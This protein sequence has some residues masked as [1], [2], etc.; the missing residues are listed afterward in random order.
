MAT[1]DIR[2]VQ[3]DELK[4][5]EK[6]AHQIWHAHYPGI[7]SVAQI[8]Y[9]LALGYAP[10]VLEQNLAEGTRIDVLMLD[11]TMTGF[12][13]YGPCIRRIVKLHKCYLDVGAH[14]QGLGQ[15]MLNHVVTEAAHMKAQTLTLQ[16]NKQNQ[17]AIRAYVRRGFEIAE[18]VVD[19]IG[20]GFV[21]DDYVMSLKVQ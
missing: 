7:I 5:L 21:M 20:N 4:T 15:L 16:V 9:M 18:S 19:D 8:D 3:L 17:T 1:P 12:M 6:L 13:A 11:D 14:G 2:P 10:S